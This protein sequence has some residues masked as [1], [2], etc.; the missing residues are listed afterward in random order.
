MHPRPIE[1]ET[2]GKEAIW[3]LANLPEILMHGKFKSH[4]FQE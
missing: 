4:Q 1:A 2:G 3:A